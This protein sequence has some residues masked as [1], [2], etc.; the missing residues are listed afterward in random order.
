MSANKLSV[1]PRCDS[2][3]TELQFKSPVE[4]VWELYRCTTC[5]FAW[6]STE[7]EH[8]TDPKLYDPTFKVKPE[9][10][11]DYPVMPAIPPLEQ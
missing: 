8:M 10:L 6:R 1:C 5:L 7:P 9:E 3:T 4:G 11:G 2:E